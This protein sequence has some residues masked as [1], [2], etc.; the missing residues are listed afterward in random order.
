MRVLQINNFHFIKGGADR[1]YLNTSKLLEDNGHSV[2]NFSSANDENIKSKYSKFFVSFKDNRGSN[3]F[4]KI[5]GVKDYL[6]NRSAKNKLEALIR[7]YRPEIAHLHLFYG[8]LTASILSVLNEFNIPVVLTVHDYRLLCPANAFLDKRSMICEKCKGKFYLNCTIN[9]CL[10][11]DFFYSSILTLEAY[12]RKYLIDPLNYIDHFIFVSHFSRQKHIEY[13]NRFSDRSTLLY[14]FT[15]I[16]DKWFVNR[17]R[18]NLLFFGRLSKEKG[19]LTLLKALENTNLKLKI[20][21][22]GP[23][24]KDVENYVSSFGNVELLGHKSGNELEELIND[25]SYI[26]VPSEWYENNPM[27]VIEAFAHGR[28]VI[29]SDIGGIPEAVIEMGTGFL[30]KS[31]SIDDLKISIKKAISLGDKDY[32]N[33]S[34]SARYFAEKNFSSKSHYIKLMDIY[35]KVL[36]I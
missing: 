5:S 8:G 22:S 31:R 21:G 29:G 20:A 10:E 17:N 12:T 24:E 11:N 33:L 36:N 13:D 34:E 1:V 15:F 4:G 18:D 35:S 30:H 3:L 14:N 19:L 26:I 27:T 16:P 9:K 25:A 28:P 6:Y 23:L 2:I 7:E 32:S